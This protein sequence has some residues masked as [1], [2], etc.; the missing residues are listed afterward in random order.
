MDQLKWEITKRV[1]VCFLSKIWPHS[2]CVPLLLGSE[3]LC[4]NPAPPANGQ[5]VADASGTA[6]LGGKIQF[7]CNEGYLLTGQQ[8]LECQE[9]RQFNGAPPTC[10]SKLEVNKIPL[11]PP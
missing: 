5:M 4:A 10:I 6:V 7:T 1:N 2:G 9:N 11:H 3:I 8:E